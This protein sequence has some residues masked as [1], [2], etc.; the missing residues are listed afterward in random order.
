MKTPKEIGD[1]VRTLRG[2]MSLRDFAA[3]CNISHTTID[4]IEKGVDFRTGKPTQVK[5]ATLEKI[6]TACGV[7]VSYIIGEPMITQI[8]KPGESIDLNA[9]QRGDALKVA[10]FGGDTEVTDEMWNEVMSYA[11]FIKQKYGKS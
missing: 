4:N 10:L 9:D 5:M 6:A 8:A 3:M 11:E 2:K 1:V 7:N